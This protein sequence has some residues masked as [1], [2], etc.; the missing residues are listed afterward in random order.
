M[1]NDKT[2]PKMYPTDSFLGNDNGGLA[3]LV[4][5][6]LEGWRVSQRAGRLDKLLELATP[7]TLLRRQ[8]YPD[9]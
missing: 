1:C 5:G 6:L 7:R 3:G 9:H 8:H 4:V 2:T